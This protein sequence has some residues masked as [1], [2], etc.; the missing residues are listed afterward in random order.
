MAITLL[1]LE[2]VGAAIYLLLVDLC[3]R[4]QGNSLPRVWRETELDARDAWRARRNP[5]HRPVLNI[6]RC[7][8]LP[9][10]ARKQFG[11]CLM[12]PLNQCGHSFEVAGMRLCCHP[13]AKKII[14]QTQEAI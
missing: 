5:N 3:L 7:R 10:G 6:D 2:L 8:A 4:A 1:L 11:E 13:D 14:L 12:S 9:L